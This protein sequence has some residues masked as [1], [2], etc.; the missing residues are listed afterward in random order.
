MILK[1][2][3]PPRAGIPRSIEKIGDH[4][5]R[6]R[7][8]RGLEQHQVAR[9]LRVTDSTVWNWENH[10]SSPPVPQCRRV[11][12]FLGYDP[13]PIPGTFSE[14]L[15]SFRRLKGLRVKDAALLAKVDPASWSSWEREEHKITGAYRE[16]ILTILAQ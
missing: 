3:S 11:I 16:R 5:R 1:A 2:D 15:V 14:K 10:R 9:I 7:I 4:L 12:E 6:T 13:F 8:E